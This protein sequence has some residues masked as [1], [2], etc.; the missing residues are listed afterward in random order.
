MKKR[1]RYIYIP[2][3]LLSLSITLLGA[4]GFFDGLHA[5]QKVIQTF[6]AGPV[7]VPKKV[8]YKVKTQFEWTMNDPCPCEDEEAPCIKTFLNKDQ[9]SEEPE[10]L[11]NYDEL[12]QLSD[13]YQGGNLVPT[14]I[15]ESSVRLIYIPF[16]GQTKN[17]KESK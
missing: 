14:I 9:P 13:K 11:Q 4:F 12:N 5:E 3:Y 7:K 17:S 6:E 10:D 15:R 8:V 2:F 1:V 16:C